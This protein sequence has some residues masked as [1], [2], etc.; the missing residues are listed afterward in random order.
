MGNVDLSIIIPSKNN[1]TTIKNI[2]Q[3][4]AEELRDTE[5]EIIV[6][7]MNSSDN[8]VIAA[9]EEIK[10]NDLRGCVIQSG[11]SSV[12]SA[13]NTG[14]FKSDG[15]YITF[16]Y[17]GRL[18]KNYIPAY[19]KTAAD[20][21]ADVVFAVP[22]KQSAAKLR[23]PIDVKDVSSERIDSMLLTAALIYSKVS[24]DFSAAM[25]KRDFLLDHHIRFFEE[26]SFGYVEAFIY[27]VLMYDPCIACSEIPLRRDT[28]QNAVIDTITENINCYQRIDAICKVFD[29]IRLKR[30]DNK[31][32]IELFEYQKIP[33]V[34]MGV[35]DI[36]RK[37]GFSASA[38]KK[39]MKQ[40]GYN[41][42]LKISLRTSPEL[43]KKIIRW[44]LMSK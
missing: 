12:T 34:V 8:T 14:I 31:T 6:I 25:L 38:I 37:E 10:K 7:D 20:T 21:N 16:V 43:R 15:R 26:F 3:N 19:L 29:S 23:A 9:L 4:I 44:K 28:E 40:K 1:Q 36:L 33:S 32:L 22:S 35:A 24:F 27:N 39:T 13:L 5:V 17:S 2:I 41:K 18:Y 11:G 42:L 30:R